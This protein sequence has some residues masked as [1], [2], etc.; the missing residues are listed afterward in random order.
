MTSSSD[1]DQLLTDL[2]AL[3]G[4]ATTAGEV[5]D[6]MALRF[7]LGVLPPTL[8]DQQL[9]LVDVVAADAASSID[10]D[11]LAE[12]ASYLLAHPIFQLR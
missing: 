5:Y 2:N 7:G 10:D 4:S 3:R 9:A 6:L 8:R 11:E 12:L 1:A